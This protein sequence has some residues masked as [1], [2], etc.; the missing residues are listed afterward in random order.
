M[1]H[2][3]T[4]VGL[5]LLGLGA[6]LAGCGW[7]PLYADREAPQA[8]ADL[9]AI[10]VAPIPERIGQRLELALR[11]SFNPSGIPTPQRYVLRVT[12]QVVRL[13]LGIQ[14]Q[15]LGTR[16]RLD[17]YANYTLTDGKSRAVINAGTS[18]AAES[19][20][21]LANQYSNVVAEDDARVRAAEELRR[22]LVSRIL[23]VMHHRAAEAAA[24]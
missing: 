24:K 19:F 17:V 4:F 20:D 12:L 14:T 16:G 15:G 9:R 13:D 21:I 11:E 8:D 10:Y 22:D 1:P 3:R 7:E 23:I 6:S 2:R 18:H 5:L